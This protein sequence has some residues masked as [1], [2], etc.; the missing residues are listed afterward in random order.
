MP[1]KITKTAEG[2]EVIGMAMIDRTEFGVS[3]NSISIDNQIKE[4]AIADDFYLKFEV[5]FE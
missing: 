2:Y 5:V 1:L 3:F 4:N